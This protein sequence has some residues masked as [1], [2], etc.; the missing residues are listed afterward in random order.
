[1]PKRCISKV[2]ICNLSYFTYFIVSTRHKA[3]GGLWGA[4]WS[5]DD[6]SIASL[7]A[8]VSSDLIWDFRK[9]PFP[10]NLGKYF[11]KIGK[12]SAKIHFGL[13]MTPI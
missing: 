5:L 10:S 3:L 9:L 4:V 2:K 12:I 13:G 6:I 7:R 11:T 8:P 1:M